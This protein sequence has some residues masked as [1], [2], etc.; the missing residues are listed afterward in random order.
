MKPH[1][2]WR[3]RELEKQ[4][5]ELWRTGTGAILLNEVGTAVNVRIVRLSYAR[6]AHA[7]SEVGVEM[8]HE[9][10]LEAVSALLVP[11]SRGRGCQH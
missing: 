3:S 9:T 2:A 6:V 8:Y 11:F 5:L 10:R 4:R 7:P 1:V